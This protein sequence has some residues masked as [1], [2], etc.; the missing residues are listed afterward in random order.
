MLLPWLAGN[1]EAGAAS[2]ADENCEAS[3]S[4]I[5]SSHV[6]S[7]PGSIVQVEPDR[8]QHRAPGL[9]AHAMRLYLYF[10]D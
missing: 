10:S 1:V 3:S 7:K 9:P 4:E 8:D 2:A 6:G 5:F